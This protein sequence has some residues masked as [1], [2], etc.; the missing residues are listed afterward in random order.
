MEK[1]TS[2]AGRIDQGWR[3][4]FVA[5]LV[6]AA[7]LFLPGIG[8]RILYI[9][10]E[11]RY[12]LLARTMVDTGD[13]LV[14]RLGA[15]VH[16]EKTPLFIWA[17][18]ALSLAQGRVTELTAVLPAALSGIAGVGAT[19]VLG[20]RLFGARAA[21]LSAFVLATAWGYFWH[22]RMALADIM[23][24]GFAIGAAAAFATVVTTGESRRGQMAICW[25]CLGLGFSAK[26]PLGLM[27]LIPF[28]AFLIWQH[29][30]R[31]LGKLRPLMGVAIVALI[32]APWALAFALSGGESYIETVVLADYV[33]P[34]FRAW[35]RA[36]ELFFAAG[37]I[38][39]GFLPWVPFVPAAL[40]NGWW[41]AEDAGLRRRFRFLLV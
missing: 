13:W 18:A 40:R 20:R 35:D 2:G 23:V 10:D 37:P 34:R 36:G 12:A 29:G 31:G 33:G 4:A 27:P 17:I 26:G 14:P 38:G 3:W 1:N 5:P 25:A 15:E 30:W 39:V 21:W 6:V 41:R 32:S 9:G 28:G 24:T 8:Q 16:M 11:A 7:A 22:A 19:L